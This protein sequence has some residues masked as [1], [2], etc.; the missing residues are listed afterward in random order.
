MTNPYK[1]FEKLHT[2][3]IVAKA[4]DDLEQNGDLELKT[5][6]EHVVG[7]LTQQ[8]VAVKSN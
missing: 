6:R 1:Q 4:I 3:K 8:L 2:W 5:S 7:Y